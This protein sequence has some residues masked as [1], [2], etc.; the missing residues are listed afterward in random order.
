MELVQVED[1]EPEIDQLIQDNFG[2][3]ESLW[4]PKCFNL[5]YK[6]VDDQK[7]VGVCTLQWSGE[8]WILGDVCV[9]HKGRGYG[10]EIVRRV[11]ESH[12]ESIWADATSAGSEVIL[13][14][15]SFHPTSVQPWEPE[16]KGYMTC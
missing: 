15:N 10:T 2:P 16:G 3:G 6:L 14:R 11:C 1:Y 7:L 5:L 13:K 9:G 4:S 8:Y 12:P